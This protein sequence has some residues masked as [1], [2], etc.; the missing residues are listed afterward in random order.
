ML[1]LI[2]GI[3]IICSMPQ[4]AKSQDNKSKLK[5]DSTSLSKYNSSNG[6]FLADFIRIGDGMIDG[7]KFYNAHY[8][9]DILIFVPEKD[10]LIYLKTILIL[11]DYGRDYL[12]KDISRDMAVIA[13]SSDYLIN[14]AK[15]NL[16]T[17]KI[18]L[19]YADGS[20]L[21]SKFPVKDDD[22]T[23]PIKGGLEEYF[24]ITAKKLVRIKELNDQKWY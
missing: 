1:I 2:I 20:Y 14:I 17:T 5:A 11:T 9:Q 24:I 10:S 6:W 18:T 8:N 23:M 19:I 13:I 21:P 12:N 7:K 3:A 4:A 15:N 16:I 22:W